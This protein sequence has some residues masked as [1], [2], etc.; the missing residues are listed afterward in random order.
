MDSPRP[1]YDGEEG[2]AITV[3]RPREEVQR[4]WQSSEYRPS[5][6]DGAWQRDRPL[7]S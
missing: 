2:E 7:A 6:I 5:S 1:V 4:L 3:N